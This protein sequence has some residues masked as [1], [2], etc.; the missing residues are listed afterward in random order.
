MVYALIQNGIVVNTVLAG[1]NDAKDPAYL[2]LDIT[3]LTPEPGI[4]WTYDNGVFTA[5]VQIINNTPPISSIPFVVSTPTRTLNTNFSPSI[6]WSTLCTYTILITC[7]L[8]L[9]SGQ[10][11]TVELRSDTN[12]TPITPRARVSNTNSGILTSGLNITNSQEFTLSFL[13]PPGYNVLLVS[14]GNATITITGQ[15]EVQLQF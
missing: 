7:A 15:S 10:S 3:S 9:N 6:S 4:G 2:W 8:S 14:S 1:V 5:P 12:P 11:G 13:V